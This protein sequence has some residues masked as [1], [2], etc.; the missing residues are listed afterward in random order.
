MKVAVIGAGSWGTALAQVVA[1]NN[2]EVLLW[3]RKD[4]VVRGIN[5]N[6]ANPRYLSDVALSKN[7]TATKRHEEAL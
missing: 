3:A 7:I 4:E 6:H 5:E 2:N 1:K